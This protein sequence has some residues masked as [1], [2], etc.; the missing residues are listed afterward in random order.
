MSTI[1]DSVHKFAINSPGQVK[2]KNLNLISCTRLFI[3]F[4]R[5]CTI[6]LW[7][8]HVLVCQIYAHFLFLFSCIIFLHSQV[9]GYILAGRCPLQIWS[10]CCHRNGKNHKRSVS[11]SQCSSFIANKLDES[12][13]NPKDDTLSE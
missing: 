9:H 13:S 2:N 11:H 10:S 12:R 4:I 6:R 7:K 3:S 1:K 5:I 8:E